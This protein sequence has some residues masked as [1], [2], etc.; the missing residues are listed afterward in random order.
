MLAIVAVCMSVL[1]LVAAGLALV[2]P[3]LETRSLRALQR[4]TEE[5]ISKLWDCVQAEIRRQAVR[6]SRLLHPSGRTPS[7]ET[8]TDPN[9]DELLRI[10][11]ASKG[12]N[13]AVR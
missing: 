2:R 10:F 1:A 12:G 3:D 13:N 4:V 9:R 6:S 8:P 11:E 7:P 5:E